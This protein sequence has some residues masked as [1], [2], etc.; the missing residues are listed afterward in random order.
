MLQLIDQ[1]YHSGLVSAPHGTQITL[2][3]ICAAH[4][5]AQLHTTDE[6]HEITRY[7]ARPLRSKVLP[8]LTLSAIHYIHARHLCIHPSKSDKHTS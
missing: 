4:L 8:D 3:I 7:Q 1:R 5:S 2:S 6:V